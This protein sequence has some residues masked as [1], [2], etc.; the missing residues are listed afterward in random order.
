MIFESVFG[1]I[2]NIDEILVFDFHLLTIKHFSFFLHFF[3]KKKNRNIYIK[4]RWLTSFRIKSFEIF[5]IIKLE[6][7]HMLGLLL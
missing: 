7:I 2:I 4:P 5:V 6:Y 1:L 3:L